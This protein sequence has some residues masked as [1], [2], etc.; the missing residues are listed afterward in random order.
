[1]IPVNCVSRFNAFC[2]QDEDLARQ[3]KDVERKDLLPMF[4]RTT[5]KPLEAASNETTKTRPRSLT[6]SGTAA[7]VH[8]TKPGFSTVPYSERTTEMHKETSNPETTKKPSGTTERL[9]T[10]G[11]LPSAKTKTEPVLANTDGSFSQSNRISSTIKPTF[12][13]QSN[14]AVTVSQRSQS[15]FS[16]HTTVC[17]CFGHLF[18]LLMFLHSLP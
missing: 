15:P 14:A 3:P 18:D 1:M 9:R 8:T 7:V 13:S 5:R 2:F 12:Y 11:I 16:P 17:P 10:P 4:S 6:A